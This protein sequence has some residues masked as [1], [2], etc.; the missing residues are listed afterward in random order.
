M[1]QTINGVDELIPKPAQ[2]LGNSI[3]LWHSRGH[4]TSAIYSKVAASFENLI[5]VFSFSLY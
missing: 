1:H 5:Q 4:L 3:W 2:L